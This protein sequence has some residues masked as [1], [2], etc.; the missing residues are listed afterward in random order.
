VTQALIDQVRRA[1][2][3]AGAAW[4]DGPT[5]AYRQLA[6]PLLD[7]VGDVRGAPVLDVGTGTGVL[8]DALV[9]RGASVLGIDL[10]LG[11]LQQEAARRP[12]AAVGDVRALPVRDG[13]VTLV[14]ASFVLNHLDAPVPAVRELRR[15]L[16]PGGR[17]LAST[18]AGEAAHPAK[19]AVDDAARAFGFEPPAWYV[20]MKTRAMPLLD[21][22]EAFAKAGRAGGLGDV[23]VSRSE[24][25][26]VLTPAEL[27][28]W[29]LGMPHTAAFVG[30]L[31]A[32]HRRRLAE[33]AERA[34][35]DLDEPVVLSVLVL[36]GSAG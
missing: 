19:A 13:A 9:R 20:A 23:V 25:E 14:T 4:A 35:A 3:A 10:S 33:R 30:R 26:L 18:F 21:T 27:V 22:P 29:R 5:R 12:A 17:L 15:V 32:G 28:T 24:V 2:D 6:Q 7:R 16:R 8:A 34:L 1:Y 36:Q 11:M 31:P